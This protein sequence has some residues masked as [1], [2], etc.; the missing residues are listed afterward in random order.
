MA[1]Q[2][3]DDINKNSGVGIIVGVGLGVLVTLVFKKIGIGILMG[4]IVAFLL[5]RSFK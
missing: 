1:Q 3:K 5:R 2:K 4:I